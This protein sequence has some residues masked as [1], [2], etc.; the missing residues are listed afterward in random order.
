M[1]QFVYDTDAALEGSGGA[2]YRYVGNEAIITWRLEETRDL[3][4]AVEIV[5][6]LRTRIAARGE[7]YRS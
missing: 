7:E 1:N 4:D 5:F 3:S 2:M 6:R